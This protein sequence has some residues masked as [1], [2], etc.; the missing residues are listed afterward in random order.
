MVFGALC[1]SFVFIMLVGTIN[2]PRMNFSVFELRESKK[3]ARYVLIL[4]ILIILSLN[5]MGA[6]KSYFGFKVKEKRSVKKALLQI[7][8]AI[9]EDEMDICIYGWPLQCSSILYQPER[10]RLDVLGDYSICEDIE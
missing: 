8:A 7:L 5:A 6:S 4:E 2:H 1:I 10:P 3:S 9:A